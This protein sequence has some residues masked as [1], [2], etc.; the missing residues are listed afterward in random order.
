MAKR[1][2]TYIGGTDFDGTDLP[3]VVRIFEHEFRMD[4]PVELDSDTFPGGKA[5]FD[6][7][8]KKLAT[9]AHFEEFK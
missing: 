4:T 7:A 8:V 1:K 5:K 2:F 3:G 6:H 9:H